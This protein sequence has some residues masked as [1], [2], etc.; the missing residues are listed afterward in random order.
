MTRKD[1]PYVK[2]TITM[3]GDTISGEPCEVCTEADKYISPLVERDKRV[4]YKKMEVSTP[5]G[6]KYADDKKV[7]SIPYFEDCKYYEGKDKPE[8]KRI[9]GFD[10]EDWSD[11]EEIKDKPVTNNEQPA[12]EGKPSNS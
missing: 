4:E 11:L 3:T 12:E 10:T 5:E 1:E 7:S 8:C 2:R 6:E 9:K